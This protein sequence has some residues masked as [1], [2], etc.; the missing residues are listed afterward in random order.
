MMTGWDRYHILHP[1]LSRDHAVP[2]VLHAMC[3]FIC[4][5]L[6]AVKSLLKKHFLTSY[7]VS[8]EGAIKDKS[9]EHYCVERDML[10]K[11]FWLKQ[12]YQGYFVPEAFSNKINL[13]DT[14]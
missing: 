14:H 12:R 8:F 4:S 13:K 7:Y 5:V 10:F 2:Y 6:L 3:Y 1:Y 9:Q 11:L